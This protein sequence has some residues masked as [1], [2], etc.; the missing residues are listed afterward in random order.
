MLVLP[1]NERKSFTASAIDAEVRSKEMR[2]KG[3][4]VIYFA[5]PAEQVQ[6]KL[7][8][9]WLDYLLPDYRYRNSWLTSVLEPS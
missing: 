3:N 7:R 8:C 4:R 6:E 2:E 9:L 1:R 5:P